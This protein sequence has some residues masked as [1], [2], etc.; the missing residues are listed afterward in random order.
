MNPGDTT[1]A[2]RFH[3]AL[4]TTRPVH[5][6]IAEDAMRAIQFAEDMA[7]DHRRGAARAEWSLKLAHTQ[8]ADGYL[9]TA[10]TLAESLGLACGI[11]MRPETVV[12]PALVSGAEEANA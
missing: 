2:R 11:W 7:Q 4:A 8:L 12:V 6:S 9:G 3:R 5:G 10:C 1:R